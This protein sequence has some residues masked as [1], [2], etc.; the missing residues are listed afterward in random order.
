MDIACMLAS[1][2]HRA[3]EAGM[4]G[5]IDG[6]LGAV[7]AG[8]GAMGTGARSVLELLWEEVASEGGG[9]GW[10]GFGGEG[11]SRDVVSLKI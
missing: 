6:A 5:A 1:P 10:G 7:T 4:G 2:I 9:W 11:P 3:V 8:V